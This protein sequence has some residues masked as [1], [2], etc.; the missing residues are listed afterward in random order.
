[1]KSINATRWLRRVVGYGLAAV[2]AQF[3]LLVAT[4]P[5]LRSVPPISE[6]T[7]A[8]GGSCIVVHD[9]YGLI[10]SWHQGMIR[11]IVASSFIHRDS[12]RW[13]V[14]V[15]LSDVAQSECRLSVG[16]WSR[17]HELFGD[18]RD[19]EALADSW[20]SI[21]V[22]D[23]RGWPFRIVRCEYQLFYESDHH[24]VTT[25]RHIVGGVELPWL[26]DG[27]ES[28]QH[29]PATLPLQPVWAGLMLNTVIWS[30]LIMC[31]HML[32]RG[33][34]RSSAIEE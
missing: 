9:D 12:R 24:N 23:A 3:L 22:E 27:S 34:K 29:I 5:L 16:R 21:R 7:E 31:F 20:P 19:I 32:Y 15:P 6:G 28:W 17:A 26:G 2:A 30:L 8:S 25:K 4:V 1:M 10:L 18:D 33:M 13:S 14:P 11:T